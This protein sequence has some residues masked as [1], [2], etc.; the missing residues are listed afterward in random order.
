[1]VIH[2][3]K[4]YIYLRPIFAMKLF[5]YLP[6]VNIQKFDLSE[7]WKPQNCPDFDHL[8]FRQM[9]QTQTK[10]PDFEH[11]SRECF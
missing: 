6:T 10:V 2:F 9:S 11:S 7:F 4:I 3:N 5:V 8:D 1:M